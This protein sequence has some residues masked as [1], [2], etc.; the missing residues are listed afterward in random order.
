MERRQ[1]E[2]QSLSSL[3]PQDIPDYSSVELTPEEIERALNFARMN[4]FTELQELKK[5]QARQE[6]IR[7]QMI[8]WTTDELRQHVKDRARR[9]PFRFEIDQDNQHVF[10]LLCLYFSNNAEFEKYGFVVNGNIVNQYSLNKGICLH[11]KERGSGKTVFMD[12]FSL[13][14]RSCFVVMA[15]AKI[16]R[17]FE[18]DGD[19]VIDRFAVPWVCE[20]GPQFFYQSPI[21]ICFDDLGDEEIKVHYGNRENVMNRVLTAIYGENPNHSVFPFFHATTNL[22][23]DEIEAKYDKRVRS[24]MREMFNWIELPGKDRRK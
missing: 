15:T 21:G 19:K 6:K 11:S 1:Q 2:P 4:K 20:R 9:L 8:P 10:D 13:N 23:G 22:T 16:C 24:R 5:K 17:F 14:R 7:E 3:L 12:L 18:S